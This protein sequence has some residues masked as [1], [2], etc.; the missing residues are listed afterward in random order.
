MVVIGQRQDISNGLIINWG[1]CAKSSA[2]QQN[3]PIAFETK[4]CSIVNMA[5]GGY[6]SSGWVAIAE[7]NWTRNGNGYAVYYVAIG[8]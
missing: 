7:T 2:K 3:Y 4:V 8:Y 1:Y 6:A 5:E